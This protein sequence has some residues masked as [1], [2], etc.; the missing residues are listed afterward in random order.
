MPSNWVEELTD[1]MHMP[2]YSNTDSAENIVKIL[3]NAKVNLN[4]QNEVEWTALMIASTRSDTGSAN[5]T[6]KIWV[7]EG[8]Y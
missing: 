8:A 2:E 7:D 6:V 3:V 1:L 5:D 4:L